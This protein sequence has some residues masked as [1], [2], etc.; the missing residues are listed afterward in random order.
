MTVKEMIDQMSRLLKDSP[1]RKRFPPEVCIPLL[2]GA[3]D[4]L[5]NFLV[6]A[7]NFHSLASITTTKDITPSGGVAAFP[8][9]YFAMYQ[10]N[11]GNYIVEIDDK[12]ATHIKDPGLKDKLT[13]SSSVCYASAAHPAFYLEQGGVIPYPTA[14]KKVTLHYVRQ[15]SAMSEQ[16][17]EC[18]LPTRLHPILVWAA[19]EMA[20]SIEQQADVQGLAAKKLEVM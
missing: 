18:E 7:R 1:K 4:W 17:A 12:V 20:A 19:V 11:R 10:D 6:M 3:Q 13:D 5:V 14:A 9:D 8:D 2:N 15:P 16:N